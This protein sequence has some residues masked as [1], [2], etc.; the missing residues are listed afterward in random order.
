MTHIV[1]TP[2]MC[3]GMFHT[4]LK[5]RRLLFI[6]PVSS[7]YLLGSAPFEFYGTSWSNTESRSQPRRWDL[8]RGS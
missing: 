7:S 5:N 6:R 2:D 8:A 1:G 3:P 4:C